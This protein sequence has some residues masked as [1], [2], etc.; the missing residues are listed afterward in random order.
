MYYNVNDINFVNSDFYQ[1]F[2]KDNPV[3]GYLKI[4]AYAARGAVPISGVKIVVTKYIDD[5]KVTFYEGVTNESGVIE[6]ISL[7]API[8]NENDLIKPNNTIYDIKSTY[9]G[10]DANYQVRIY[11]N[12]L[13][14]QPISV[15]PD[16]S[17]MGGI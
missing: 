15:T 1:S 8:L 9:D 7:P 12:V 2:L 5:E 11:E 6:K 10:I 17:K 16:M 4:R 14:I 13:V 3:V